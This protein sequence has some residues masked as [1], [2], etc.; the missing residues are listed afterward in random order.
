MQRRKDVG[1][2]QADGVYGSKTNGKSDAKT[3]AKIVYCVGK[4]ADANVGD[5][6]DDDEAEEE[7]PLKCVGSEAEREVGCDEKKSSEEFD[8]WV[9]E[10]D[11]RGAGAAFAAEPKPGEYRNVIVGLDRRVAM[12]ATRA[13][14][15]DGDALWNPRDA[16]VQKA[17]DE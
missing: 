3:E 15:H 2:A 4:D 7:E 10:G 1:E 13:G 5:G 6:Q 12:W 11:W 17:A 16:D 9:H 14:R 8:G